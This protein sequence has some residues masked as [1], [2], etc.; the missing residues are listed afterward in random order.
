MPELKEFLIN[1]TEIFIK[2]NPFVFYLPSLIKCYIYMGKK[3]PTFIDR[4]E[5]VKYAAVAFKDKD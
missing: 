4:L 1:F 5:R 3:I 2:D